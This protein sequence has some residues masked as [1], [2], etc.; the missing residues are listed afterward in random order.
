MHTT[1][2][3]GVH[4]VLVLVSAKQELLHVCYHARQCPEP[5][6]D[7]HRA[8]PRL[9]RRWRARTAYRKALRAQATHVRQ[10]CTS[11]NRHDPTHGHRVPR[12]TP[13]RHRCSARRPGEPEKVTMDAHDKVNILL[14][15]DQPATLRRYEVILS[16]LG[17]NLL[18]AA[19]GREALAHLLHTDIAVVL[20]DVHML[21]I[22]G[23]ALARMMHQHPRCQ[24]TAIL[25][26]ASVPLRDCDM[27][28]G[29]APGVVDY[30]PVPLIP[31]L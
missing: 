4:A 20:M 14:V 19:S 5:S 6:E 28:R 27:L 16:E 13:S 18:K 12:H 10:A 7:V 31:E 29:S 24:H 3:G 22:D 11:S 15:D 2:S 30:L 26:I 17:E 21:E 23:F 1:P 8:A 25:F 9:I